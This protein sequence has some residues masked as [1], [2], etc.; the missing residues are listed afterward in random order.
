MPNVEKKGSADQNSMDGP[1]GADPVQQVPGLA[2]QVDG[3]AFSPS[4]PVMLLLSRLSG[5]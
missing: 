3:L 2:P 1:Q 4:P 5:T